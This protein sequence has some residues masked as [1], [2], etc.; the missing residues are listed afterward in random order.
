MLFYIFAT[1]FNEYSMPMKQ[2][3]DCQSKEEI[4]FAIDSIDQEVIKLF[5]RRYEYVKAIIPFKEPTEE[6]ILARDRYDAVISSRREMAER[7]GLDPEVIE[8]I[9]RI[10]MDYFITQE[11]KMIKK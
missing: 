1:L 2:A 3:G 4:R 5:G 8:K 10:L 7:E 6:S 11:R 9:Y